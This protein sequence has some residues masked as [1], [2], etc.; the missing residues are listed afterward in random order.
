MTTT[1][2]TS[3]TATTANGGPS[4]LVPGLAF[5]ALTLGGA[6]LVSS[7][8]RSADTATH[9]LSYSQSY[10]TVLALSATL[11]FGSAIP[12]VTWV[13][14]VYPRLGDG[15]S[16]PL[17]GVA[18]G[19]L[20]TASIALGGLFAGHPHPGKPRAGPAAAR[21]AAAEHG[22]RPDGPVR[23][24]PAS[25]LDL[26]GRMIHGSTRPSEPSERRYRRG[27]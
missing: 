12:L 13:V 16:G 24:S 26:A 9:V 20:V 5:A 11:V 25:Y 10:G 7:T 1:P 27:C 19:A 3:P 2:G 21:Q 8:P 15:A 23:T 18:G 14:T 6:I 4:L 22:R 17:I